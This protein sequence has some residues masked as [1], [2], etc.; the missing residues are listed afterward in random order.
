MRRLAKF[1]VFLR[2]GFAYNGT[3]DMYDY[4]EP[5]TPVLR[6][7]AVKVGNSI[8]RTNFLYTY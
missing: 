7:T 8:L 6:K 2:F 1:Q 5:E 3:R 4:V